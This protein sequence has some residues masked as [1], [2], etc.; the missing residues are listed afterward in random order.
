[1]KRSLLP[2]LDRLT[3]RLAVGITLL[4][5][6]PLCLGLAFLAR[7][8][9]DHTLEARRHAAE[10]ENRMLEVALRHQMLEKD[11]RLM[12][13]I[14]EQIGRQPEVRAAMVLD[15][16][17]V[18]RLSSDPD[19]VGKR[20]SQESGTCMG[21]HAKAPEERKRWTVFKENGAEILR[22]VLPVENRPECHGCHAPEL[23]FNGMLILDISLAEIQQH[24]RRDAI[25]MLAA[26]AVMTLT[27]LAGVGFLIRRL[28][29]ARL[30]RLSRAFRSIAR[31]NLDER[32]QVEGADVLGSLAEDFNNMAE[33][34]A[35]LI[36][37]VKD[38]EQQMAGVLNSLDDGLIVLDRNY[39]VVASNSSIAHRLCAHPEDLK[40]RNCRDALGHALPCKEDSECPTTRCLKTGLLQRAIYRVPGTEGGEDRVHEVYASPVRGED[41]A[42][43]QVVESW[44]DITER[45]QEEERLAEIERLSSLGVLASGLS[46]EVNTPLAS[47]LTCADAIL[48]RLDEKEGQ[49]AEPETLAAV[50]ESA[51]IIREQVLRCR[52]ITEQFLRF[53]R[54]IPPTAGPIHLPEV[55]SSV[56]ALTIPTARE[57]GIEIDYPDPGSLPLVSANS[58]VIQHVVLNVLVNA[59]ESFKHPGGCIS[60]RFLVNSV[61]RLRITDTGCGMPREI[62]KHLFEP[63]RTQKP[64]G[65]GLGLFL[66]RR[67]MRRFGGDVCLV[68]STVGKG[69]CVEIVFPRADS[70]PS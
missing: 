32:A 2:T 27:V 14:L 21:C 5:I 11:P 60:L 56:L 59:V 52:K 49:R 41:G 46:H 50:R 15:H 10:L 55:V 9:F 18:I 31:G 63:F 48:G 39:R 51:T 68:E 65:T 25:M 34:T 12:T 4:V 29:L 70:D 53:A 22:S 42:V 47:T 6:I 33:S 7:S 35:S 66:S 20:I 40:G 8:H 28:V 1:M 16:D 3:A 17:G 64:R 62:Q 37:T 44:R 38:R 36:R 24:L 67:F 13:E 19:K 30:L 58:E 23:A 45:V 61:V 54:G 57:G 43:T 69:S 26:T